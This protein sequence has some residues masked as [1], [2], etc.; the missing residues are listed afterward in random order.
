MSVRNKEYHDASGQSQNEAMACIWAADKIDNSHLWSRVTN[1]RQ[2]WQAAIEGS[3]RDPQSIAAPSDKIVG[4]RSLGCVS[5]IDSNERTVWIAHA[6]PDNG[7]RFI[8]RADEMLT[9]FVE[10]QRAIHE[11]AVSLIS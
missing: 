11:F 9:A 3:P 6:H 2:R 4:G 7:K 8:V 5:A 10:L 1:F